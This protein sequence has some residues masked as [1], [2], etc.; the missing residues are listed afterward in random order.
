M[1]VATPG[2]VNGTTLKVWEYLF[3]TRGGQGWFYSTAGITGVL[4]SAIL[5]VMIICSQPFV[6][7]KGHFEVRKYIII[8]IISF[9]CKDLCIIINFTY[10]FVS[11]CTPFLF[12]TEVMYELQFFHTQ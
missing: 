5:I 11:L 12:L 7:R 4:L 6:R 9:N 1:L 10:C 2:E 8:V 3:T